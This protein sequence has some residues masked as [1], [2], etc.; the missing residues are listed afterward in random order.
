MERF[1]NGV[2]KFVAVVCAILF[3]LAAGL[4]LLLFNAEKRL[5]DAESYIRALESQ[6]FYERLPAL[7]AETL[8][9]APDSNDPPACAF[10]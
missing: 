6:D 3:V 1:F 5:F 10:T 8:A 7:V 9:A 4:A 2:L